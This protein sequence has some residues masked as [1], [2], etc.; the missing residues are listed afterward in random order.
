M[1]YPQEDTD[2]FPKLNVELFSCQADQL[3][4]RDSTQKTTS[5]FQMGKLKQKKLVIF[6]KTA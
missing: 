1:T 6:K 3:N 2:Q 5:T 4:V